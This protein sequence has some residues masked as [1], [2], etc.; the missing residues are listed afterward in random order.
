MSVISWWP[1]TEWS[2]CHADASLPLEVMLWPSDGD[3]FCIQGWGLMGG[4]SQGWGGMIPYYLGYSFRKPCLACVQEMTNAELENLVSFTRVVKARD[5]ASFYQS[6]WFCTGFVVWKM[7]NLMLLE[8]TLLFD[9]LS[10]R[11]LVGLQSLM[12]L[13]AWVNLVSCVHFV[14]DCKL[15]FSSFRRMQF[16]FLI[17]FFSIQCTQKSHKKVEIMLPYAFSFTIILFVSFFSYHAALFSCWGGWNYDN[18]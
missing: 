10:I 18:H 2:H 5:A 17:S 1:P 13:Q 9:M 7:S 3:L 12:E 6:A 11:R 16:L 15:L 14:P 4:G 8:A